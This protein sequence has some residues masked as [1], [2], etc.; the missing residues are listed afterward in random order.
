[1]DDVDSSEYDG[2]LVIVIDMVNVL[3]IDDWCF[4]NGD[5][6]IKIDYYFNDEFYGDFMWVD[7]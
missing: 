3:W 5:E 6:L 2:V 7:D 1:M 4:N